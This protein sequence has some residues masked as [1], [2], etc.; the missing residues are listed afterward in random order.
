MLHAGIGVY[1]CV[2]VR[3]RARVCVY[4]CYRTGCSNANNHK[5]INPSCETGSISLVFFEKN[6]T[7]FIAEAHK[8]A[9]WDLDFGI[10]LDAEVQRRSTKVLKSFGQISTMSLPFANFRPFK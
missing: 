2:C 7:N 3:A 1:V 5:D 9:S 8:T 10:K 6:E 4:F